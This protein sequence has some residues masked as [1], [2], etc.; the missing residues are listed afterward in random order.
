MSR[1]HHVATGEPTQRML[2]VAELVRHAM[3]DLLARGEIMDPVIEKHVVT[4]PRVR[5]SPDLKLA[6]VYVM[7]LGGKD[8]NGVLEALE[9]HRKHL[10]KEIATK[11][12]RSHIVH[13]REA[14]IRLMTTMN[15]RGGILYR[16]LASH[17]SKR[18][19]AS[20]PVPTA[21]ATRRRP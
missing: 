8:T 18:A 17:L 1:T 12:N 11:L 15:M 20:S 13:G 2:R 14:L 5:M 10:R 19:M 7:S 16:N 21:A 3:S 9:R 4:V 6:T